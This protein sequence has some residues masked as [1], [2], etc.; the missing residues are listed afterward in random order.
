MIADLRVRGLD[1]DAIHKFVIENCADDWEEFVECLFGYDVKMAVRRQR[2]ASAEK[3]TGRQFGTWRDPIIHWADRHLE[4]RQKERER[5]HLQRLEQKRWEAEGVEQSEARR[6]STAAANTLVDQATALR[7]LLAT[8]K[9]GDR[10]FA[11]KQHE[12]FHKMIWAAQTG[13]LEPKKPSLLAPLAGLMDLLFGPR[14]RILLG[15]FLLAL[16]ALW[17]QRNGMLPTSLA[18]VQEK[19]EAGELTDTEVLVQDW[20][21]AF[22]VLAADSVQQNPI[23]PL[24]IPGLPELFSSRLTCANLGM[25]GLILLLGSMMYGRWTGVFLFPAVLVTLFGSALGVPIL[26]SIRGFDVTASLIGFGMLL[27]GAIITGRGES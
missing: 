4:R 13:E 15:V 20:M 27:L 8:C 12:L 18:S 25:A 21:P 22:G 19:Y 17:L 24:I 3:A 5:R 2:A 7:E 9:P 23:K 16:C 10:D 26:M 1:E 14:T 11:K 6:R